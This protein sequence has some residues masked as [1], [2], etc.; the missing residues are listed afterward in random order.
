VIIELDDYERMAAFDDGY[1]DY[2]IDNRKVYWATSDDD[3]MELVVY[4]VDD[5][6]RDND[7]VESLQ[8]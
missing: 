5:F 2:V 7:P 6:I 1:S 4:P 3:Q 8:E